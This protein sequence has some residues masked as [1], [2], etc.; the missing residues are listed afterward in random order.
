MA[1]LSNE[2]PFESALE[3]DKKFDQREE[4]WIKVEFRL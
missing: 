3:A 4:R 1:I 2:I